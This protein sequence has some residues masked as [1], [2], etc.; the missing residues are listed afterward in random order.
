MLAGSDTTTLA[1][2]AP[3]TDGALIGGIVGGGVALIIVVI[4]VSFVCRARREKHSTPTEMMSAAS[5]RHSDRAGSDIYHDL[6]LQ[7]ATQ[8]STVERPSSGTYE[9][10][11]LTSPYAAPPRTGRDPN[12]NAP[13]RTSMHEELT[14]K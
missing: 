11:Q 10:L 3:S 8:Y 7:P 14:L 9:E 6:S 5:E 12:Y 2:I 4:V 1:V 13:P